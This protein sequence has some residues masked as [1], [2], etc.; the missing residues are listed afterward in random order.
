MVDENK[1]KGNARKIQIC[2]GL[3]EEL[4]KNKNKGNARK[5]Q[6]CIGLMES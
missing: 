5:M 2:I 4:N 6:I 1:S 3:M